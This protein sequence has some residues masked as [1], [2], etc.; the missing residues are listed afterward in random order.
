MIGLFLVLP[1]ALSILVLS[2][3]W[4]VLQ[5]QIRLE[6]EH[7]VKVHGDEYEKYLHQVRRWI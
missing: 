2:E 3:G 5:I 7:L 6:E 4:L 1:N